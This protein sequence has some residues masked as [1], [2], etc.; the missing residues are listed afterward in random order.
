MF[1]A[2]LLEHCYSTLRQCVKAGYLES[3][4]FFIFAFTEGK[5]HE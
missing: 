5:S 2:F 1:R 3:P 4:V